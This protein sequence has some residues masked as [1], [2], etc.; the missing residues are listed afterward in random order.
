MNAMQNKFTFEEM[1][2]D[3]AEKNVRC[4]GTRGETQRKTKPGGKTYVRGMESVGLKEEDVVEEWYSKP[5][6]PPQMMGK[7]RCHGLSV[8]PV[9]VCI[10]LK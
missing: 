7:P 2:S 10:R 9:W 8:Y 1:K 4:T 5:F 6:R 3:S